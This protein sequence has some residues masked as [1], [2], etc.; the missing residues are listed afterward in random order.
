MALIG[1]WHVAPR[2]PFGRQF[3]AIKVVDHRLGHRRLARTKHDVTERVAH[4]ADLADVQAFA[5]HHNRA[6]GTAKL[7][8]T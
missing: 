7:S 2:G 8:F 6:A 5:H 1:A 3:D 4:L